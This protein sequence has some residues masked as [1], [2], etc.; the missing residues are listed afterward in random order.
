MTPQ[1]IYRPKAFI[2]CSLRLEDKEFVEMVEHITTH[3]GFHPFGTVGRHTAAPKPLWQQM[4]DGIKEADCIVMALTPRYHHQ[5]IHD[6]KQTGQSIS[7]MLDV[8]LGMAVYKGIPIIAIASDN[9]VYGK[10][11][12]SMVSI[13]TIDT[14][15]QNDFYAKWPL[16][17]AYFTSAMKLIT[18]DTCFILMFF[19][20]FFYCRN[21]LL[22]LLLQN[23][24]QNNFV[25]IHPII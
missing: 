6:K 2:S 11:L 25:L 21:K 8:E 14:R 5:D 17:Q 9:K 1:T 12:P 19:Q 16:L 3:L 18:N 23:F 4:R 13:V 20:L 22:K 15:D 7:P 10:I 24:K